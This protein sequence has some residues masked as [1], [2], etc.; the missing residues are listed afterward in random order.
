MQSVGDGIKALIV[1]QGWIGTGGKE[2]ANKARVPGVHLSHE[3][4]LSLFVSMI[5]SRAA[6]NKKTYDIMTV[7]SGFAMQAQ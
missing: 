6:G 4:G 7:R 2:Q 3:S 1:F 5:Q